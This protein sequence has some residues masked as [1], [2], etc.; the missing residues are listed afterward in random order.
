MSI[1]FERIK[2]K[3]LD[4]KLWQYE[5]QEPKRVE[6]AVLDY[7]S[8]RGWQGYFS[9]HFD[10]IETLLCMMCWCN[11]ESYFE[12]KRKSLR[13]SGI[14]EAFDFATDGYWPFEQ[15][16]FSHSDL[17]ENAHSFQK[18]KIPRIL[19]TWI[20]RGVK[21]PVV[22]KAYLKDRPATEL[23]AEKLMSFFI[24]QGGLDY[25]IDFLEHFHCEARQRLKHRRKTLDVKIKAEYGYNSSLRNMLEKAGVHLRIYKDTDVAPTALAIRNWIKKIA[26]FE[27]SELQLE[28]L[29]LAKDVETYWEKRRPAEE[30]WSRKAVLDLTVWQDAVST[31]EV[32]APNDRLRP[33]Q[34]EQLHLDA[35]HGKK[36]WVIE[37]EEKN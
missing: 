9:E 36:S 13:I 24:A 6:L 17:M 2:L 26:E 21:S 7:L 22:G 31:I 16:K 20:E 19:E 11:R 3:R 29:S 1:V 32:K 10:F 12:E 5:D 14:D 30:R 15:H 8:A 34:I 18:E 4:R 37:V 28:L 25:F 33:N 27:K 35:K 23:S